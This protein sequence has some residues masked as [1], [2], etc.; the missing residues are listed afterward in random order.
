MNSNYVIL[1]SR[2]VNGVDIHDLEKDSRNNLGAV[3]NADVDECVSTQYEAHYFV[4]VFQ[5]RP[6]ESSNQTK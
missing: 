1:V 5:K 4:K 2:N 3:L 6:S